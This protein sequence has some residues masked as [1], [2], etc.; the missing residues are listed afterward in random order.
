MAKLVISTG[1]GWLTQSGLGWLDHTD[2][3]LHFAGNA[4]PLENLVIGTGTG[5]LAAHIW[6]QKISPLFV[7]LNHQPAQR[8]Y[9]MP[10]RQ[11]YVVAQPRHHWEDNPQ[12]RS[13]IRDAEIPGLYRLGGYVTTEA[14][15]QELCRNLSGEWGTVLN[16]TFSLSLSQRRFVTAATRQA[17]QQ[18]AAQKPDSTIAVTHWDIARL[19][20]DLSPVMG[21][22]AVQRVVTEDGPAWLFEPPPPTKFR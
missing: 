16:T 12:H 18:Y 22:V 5:I 3:L 4:Q 15:A 11:G 8:L 10:W 21:Y 14:L 9:I 13:T 17:Q 6:D 7:N 19:S 2:S 20:P 1:I